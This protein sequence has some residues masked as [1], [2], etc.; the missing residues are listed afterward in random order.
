MAV[1]REVVAGRLAILEENLRLLAG[2]AELDLDSYLGDPRNYGAAERFLQLSIEAVFDI[3][4]HCISALALLRPRSYGDILPTLS[5]AGVISQQTEAELTGISG[6]RNLLVHD[7][8][9]L[10]RARVHA[11]LTTRL[12]GFRRFAAEIARLLT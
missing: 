6:F 11:F 4:T 1:D 3:G 8:A 10:D 2:L 12:D 7:Y 9:H 5:R